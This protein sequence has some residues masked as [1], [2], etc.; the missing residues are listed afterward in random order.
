MEN[1]MAVKGKYYLMSHHHHHHHWSW[2]YLP[3][4]TRIGLPQK[5]AH[6]V[7]ICCIEEAARSIKLAIIELWVTNLL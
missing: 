3:E 4:Y 2:P 6:L 7:Y 1:I 5:V